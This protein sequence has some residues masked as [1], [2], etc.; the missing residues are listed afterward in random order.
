MEDWHAPTCSV[1]PEETVMIR[2]CIRRLP[3]KY[4]EVIL[5]RYSHGYSVQEISQILRLSEASVYKRLARG[6]TLLEKYCK[7]E[8]VL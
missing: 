3:N 4:R 5:L 1:D 7:E 6:K 8:D 2:D